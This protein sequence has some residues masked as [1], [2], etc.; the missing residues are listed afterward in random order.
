MNISEKFKLFKES[1]S[2]KMLQKLT[3]EN[4]NLIDTMNNHD[5][6]EVTDDEILEIGVFVTIGLLLSEKVIEECQIAEMERHRMFELFCMFALGD[7]K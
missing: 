5:P 7:L 6:D 2:V 4:R 3:H 1:E